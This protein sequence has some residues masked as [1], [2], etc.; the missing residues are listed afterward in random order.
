MLEYVK[1]NG[2]TVMINDRPQNIEAAK[3]LGWKPKETL[4][5]ES[6]KATKKTKS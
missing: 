4:K 3:S 6:K 1:P 2:T 5:K